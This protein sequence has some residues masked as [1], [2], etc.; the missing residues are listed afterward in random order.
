MVKVLIQLLSK[1]STIHASSLLSHMTNISCLTCHSG[2]GCQSLLLIVEHTQSST[3]NT[4]VFHCLIFL[5]F[6]VTVASYATPP[7]Y[8][9]PIK[10]DVRLRSKVTS[11]GKLERIFFFS[12]KTNYILALHLTTFIQIPIFALC[13]HLVVLTK[14]Y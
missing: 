8:L 2:A 6:L 7:N 4:S 10:S 14:L 11:Q 5:Y 9:S 1:C 12:G 13:L 3:Q